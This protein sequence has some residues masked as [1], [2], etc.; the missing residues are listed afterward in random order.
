MHTLDVAANVHLRFPSK[1]APCSVGP[2]RVVEIRGSEVVTDEECTTGCSSFE[3]RPAF[4]A[5]DFASGSF[6]RRW[7]GPVSP[8]YN[9]GLSARMTEGERIANLFGHSPL[10]HHP[11]RDVVLA[12]A[13]NGL[14]LGAVRD[15]ST[16]VAIEESEGFAAGDVVFIQDGALLVGRIAGAVAVWDGS[17]GRR[18]FHAGVSALP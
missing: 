6:S 12:P 13:P 11:S 18:L 8:P 14:R 5:Y 2:E 3:R 9:D 1:A 16:I 7:D 17:T 4:V 15:G 10:R